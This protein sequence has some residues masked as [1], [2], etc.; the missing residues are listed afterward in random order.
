MVRIIVLVIL[1]TTYFYSYTQEFNCRV[2]V[3]HPQVQ[4]SEKEIFKNLEIDIQEFINTRRWTEHLFT[5]EEKIE[6]LLI[7]TIDKWENDNFSG[8]LQ[9]QATRPVYNSNY[10]SP[11]FVYKDNDISFKYTEFT[12]LEWDENSTPEN[13]I[14]LISYYAYLMLGLDYD[15]FELNGG[16]QFFDRASFIVQQMQSTST[17]VGSHS[18]KRVIATG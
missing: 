8:N 1:L 13:L 12:T 17:K 6:C 16:K 11:L 3:L 7:F 4:T 10:K 15:S 2:S 18:R 5:P 14:A 9:I